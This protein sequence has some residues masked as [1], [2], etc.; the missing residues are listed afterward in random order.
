MCSYLPVIDVEPRPLKGVLSF[1]TCLK[2]PALLSIDHWLEFGFVWCTLIMHHVLILVWI[3]LKWI[4]KKTECTVLE[5]FILIFFCLIRR[6]LLTLEPFQNIRHSF[7]W[8]ISSLFVIISP[9]SCKNELNV[10][11]STGLRSL[12]NKTI[13]YPTRRSPCMTAKLFTVLL[14]GDFP[15]FCTSKVLWSVQRWLGLGEVLTHRAQAHFRALAI[16]FS[17][18]FYFLPPSPHASTLY[19]WCPGQQ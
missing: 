15:S 10:V 4:L 9:I 19:L 2:N 16:V 8:S 12:G 11:N 14:W 3:S 6:L 7:H 18:H 13:I 1:A 17:F 5:F